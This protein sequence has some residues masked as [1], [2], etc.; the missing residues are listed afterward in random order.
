MVCYWLG[1]EKRRSVAA[2]TPNS[3][4]W[5]HNRVTDLPGYIGWRLN[6]SFPVPS[7]A[8]R[9]AFIAVSTCE[10]FG[11]TPDLQAPEA[12]CWLLGDNRMGSEDSANCYG[13]IPLSR[14]ES[15][16]QFRFGQDGWS[17]IHHGPIY[18]R[19]GAPYQYLDLFSREYQMLFATIVVYVTLTILI[20]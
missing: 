5:M 20:C 7:T 1:C 13:P 6:R 2:R 9:T 17:R 19:N 14:I 11:S 10:E 15:K 8:G 4:Q 12:H 16:A 3:D 18:V